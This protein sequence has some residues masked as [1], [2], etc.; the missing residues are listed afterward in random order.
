MK[1]EESNVKPVILDTPD[2]ETIIDGTLVR[3]NVTDSVIN[4]MKE[5]YSGMKLKSLDD[6][7]GYL[8][9]KSSRKEV[10]TVGILVEKL[11]KQG[12]EDAISIQKKWLNKEKEILGKIAEVQDPLDAEIKKFDD[13]QERIAVE[14]KKMQ[15]ERLMKRQQSLLKLEAKYDNGCFSLG[16]V[17]YE[18]SNI[19]E[20]D[21][22]VWEE[23]ILSKFKKEY[24]KIESVKAEEERKRLSEEAEMKRQQEELR[25]QQEE[26]RQQQLE[27][28]K[29]KAEIE[30]QKQEQERIIRERELSEQ[31]EKQKAQNELQTKRFHL[32]YPYN[33]IGSDVDMNT[34]WALD[35]EKFKTV[36]SEKKIAFE[37]QMAEEEELRQQQLEELQR[38]AIEKEQQRVAEEQRLAEIKKQEELEHASDKDKWNTLINQLSEIQI[39][40][41]KSSSYKRKAAILNEKIEEIKSL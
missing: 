37:K 5:K 40:A 32:L 10:R 38:K 20:A 4:A 28:E 19:Q 30:K 1:H 23:V 11:C 7:E 22:E 36:L 25:K 39:P 6:K 26:L 21:Y 3:N 14:E 9:I 33:T 27:F 17:S 8:E 41:M 15:E 2:L 34:L 31:L 35:E 16:G 12:R 13:E 29:Q 24:D 18:M